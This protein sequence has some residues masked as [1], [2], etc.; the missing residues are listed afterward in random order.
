[1]IIGGDLNQP[2]FSEEDLKR[3]FGKSEQ[4]PAA[5]LPKTP[6]PPAKASPV[7][8]EFSPEKTTPPATPSTND[9][10]PK[11]ETINSPMP[12]RETYREEK[13]R[14]KIPKLIFRFFGT[15]LLIFAISFSI[16]NAP[17][18]ILKMKYYWENDFR[19]QQWTSTNSATAQT[20]DNRLVIP[21]I[22]VDAPIIWN[23]PED[24]ITQKLEKGVVHYQG[25]ALP[26]QAGNVFITGHSSYYIWAPGDYKDVFALLNELSAGDQITVRYKGAQFN[27]VVTDSVTVD[28]SDMKVLEQ[29]NDEVLSLMTCVPVGTNL[30]RLIV[31]AKR[32]K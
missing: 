28:P 26:G 1:M 3:M 30:R 23:V 18:L 31:T 24:Q 7:E 8:V 32:T 6:E 11:P 27:Y 17:A 10:Y 29:G 20:A 12:F 15:F 16:I 25:T 14:F 5:P 2:I 21:K 13:D 9:I 4:P 19:N 22:K